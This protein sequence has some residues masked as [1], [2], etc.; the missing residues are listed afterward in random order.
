MRCWYDGAMN[1]FVFPC[2]CS[3]IALV[4]LWAIKHIS[5]RWDC[6][7]KRLLFRFLP[8]HY[9]LRFITWDTEP[10]ITNDRGLRGLHWIR[11][12]WGDTQPVAWNIR[13]FTNRNRSG[14]CWLHHTHVN[15]A[16]LASLP[17]ACARYVPVD[18]DRLYLSGII[19]QRL[20]RSPRREQE[21]IN[22]NHK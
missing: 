11:R 6:E 5:G 4:L 19:C 9:W 13:R 22:I 15:G 18:S 12:W 21:R 20:L 3:L 14:L 17:Y 8:L 2:F 10:V 7:H 1:V 16:P